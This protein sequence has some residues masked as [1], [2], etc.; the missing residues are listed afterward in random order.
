MRDRFPAM[1]TDPAGV[2][3]R[4]VPNPALVDRLLAAGR[5]AGLES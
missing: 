5:E 1:A 4:L 3:A 2:L